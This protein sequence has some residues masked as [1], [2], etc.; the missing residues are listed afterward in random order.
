MAVPSKA[1]KIIDAL[2]VLDMDLLER[3]CKLGDNG[4]IIC[5]GSLL[6]ESLLVREATTIATAAAME[7]DI[8]VEF[9][10]AG[11]CKCTV[12]DALVIRRGRSSNQPP[13]RNRVSTLSRWWILP[14]G[15]SGFHWIK[16]D[17][18]I[19]FTSVR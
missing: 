1:E 16:R 7:E 3:F 18:E 19:E 12:T 11:K 17:I 13:G 15:S 5:L 10:G 9:D 6:A 4:C 8:T 14:V 2:E